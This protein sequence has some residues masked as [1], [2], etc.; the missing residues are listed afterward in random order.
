MKV[1]KRNFNTE[2]LPIYK[3]DA[4]LPKDILLSGFHLPDEQYAL[5]E[6]D[7]DEEEDSGEDSLHYGDDETSVDDELGER[8]TSLVTEGKRKCHLF[9]F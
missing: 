4:R 5:I 6:R 2:N 8:G 9:R 3:I 7:G 1:L